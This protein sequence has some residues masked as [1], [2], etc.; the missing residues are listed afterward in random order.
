MEDEMGTTVPADGRTASGVADP[1]TKG[2]ATARRTAAVEVR[3]VVKEFGEIRA[4]D[5]LDLAV[6]AGKIAAV[7]EVTGSGTREISLSWAR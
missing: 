3:G 2:A 5:G 7:G 6:A 4:L 1:A